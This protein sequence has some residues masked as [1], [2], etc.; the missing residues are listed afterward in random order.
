MVWLGHR[1]RWVSRTKGF[2]NVCLQD[3]SCVDET[4]PALHRTFV[5]KLFLHTTYSCVLDSSMTTI[6][7]LVVSKGPMSLSY[8]IDEHTV[9]Q[10]VR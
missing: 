9:E 5:V 10:R 1:S 8:R 6:N 7:C 4:Q 2:G 3:I